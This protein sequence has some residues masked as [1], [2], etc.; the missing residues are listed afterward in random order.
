MIYASRPIFAA[1]PALFLARFVEGML[2]RVLCFAFAAF[3]CGSSRSSAF[4]DDSAKRVHSRST[5]SASRPGHAAPAP[6]SLF[7]LGCLSCWAA[8]FV[9]PTSLLGLLS[10]AAWQEKHLCSGPFTPTSGQPSIS[11]KPRPFRQSQPPTTPQVQRNC[12]ASCS[13]YRNTGR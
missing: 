5:A 9:G 13:A 4:S 12:C 3:C 1:V 11:P 2:S 6:V 7:L 8:F 10:C